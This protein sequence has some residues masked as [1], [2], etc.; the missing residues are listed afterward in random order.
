M[1]LGSEDLH[2]GYVTLKKR[3]VMGAA[4]TSGRMENQVGITPFGNR[5]RGKDDDLYQGIKRA[6]AIAN[7]RADG[8]LEI[9]WQKLID[10]HQGEGNP[11]L[12]MRESIVTS[13]PGV[14]RERVHRRNR[15]GWPEE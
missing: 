1:S 3:I 5:S 4:L 7:A 6:P 12:P 8:P 2:K 13:N 9:M 15:H 14:R 11:W 10:E